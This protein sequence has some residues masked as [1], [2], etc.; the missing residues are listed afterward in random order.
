MT[1]IPF[2][3]NSNIK[4]LFPDVIISFFHINIVYALNPPLWNG[5]GTQNPVYDTNDQG[6]EYRRPEAIHLKPGYNAGSHL[7]KER[8]YYECEKSKGEYIDRES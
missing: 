7:Q 2:L 8:I 3:V 4:A 1:K 6:T 5:K